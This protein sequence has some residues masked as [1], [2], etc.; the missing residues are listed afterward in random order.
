[1]AATI[2]LRRTKRL[3]KLPEPPYYRPPGGFLSDAIT[4]TAVAN[5]E[6]QVTWKVDTEDWKRDANVLTIID[7]VLQ[8]VDDGAIV[9][10]HDGGG[11]TRQATVDALPVIIDLLQAQGYGFTFPITDPA[12][13]VG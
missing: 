5:G 8:Q 2:G 6:Q 13:P 9:L 7:N 4:A 3:A 1:M 12:P 10:L 11:A